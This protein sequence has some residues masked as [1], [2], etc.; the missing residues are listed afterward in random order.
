MLRKTILEIYPELKGILNK[1][2]GKI[3]DH[4]MR[5][6]LRPYTLGEQNMKWG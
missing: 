1:L 6:E 2:A 5:N 4:Q 3:T